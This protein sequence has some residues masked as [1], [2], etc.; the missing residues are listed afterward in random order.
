M[1][2]TFVRSSRLPVFLCKLARARCVCPMKPR[3][4]K[5]SSLSLPP[6]FFHMV[7]L[8]LLLFQNIGHWAKR[9]SPHLWVQLVIVTIR[10]RRQCLIII[11]VWKFPPGNQILGWYTSVALLIM[12]YKNLKLGGR[13]G[14]SMV[15]TTGC[16]PRR[17][18]FDSQSCTW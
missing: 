2:L 10:E 13:R 3:W 8:R 11:Y 9:L 5:V 1:R 18:R 15:K 12:G 7:T 17:P 14:G 6:G 16:F 4:G